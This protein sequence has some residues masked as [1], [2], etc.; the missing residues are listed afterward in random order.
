MRLATTNLQPDERPLSIPQPDPARSRKASHEIPL[1]PSSTGASESAQYL[2]LAAQATNDALR[3]WDVRTGA[4]DWPQGLESLLGYKP[5][6]ATREIGFWQKNIHP[7]DRARTAL[8]LRDALDGSA[9][10]WSGEYRFRSAHGAY[11]HL[12]ERAAI[13]RDDEGQAVRVV[14]SLM[15]ITARKQLQD[16]LVRSQKMEAFGQLAAGVAHDFNNF[17]TTILGYSDLLLEL[18][19]I[20]GAP[21]QHIGEIRQAAKRASALTGQLMAFSR[22]QP[23]ENRVVEV[24]S[25]ITNLER[26][27]LRLLG[28]HVTVECHLHRSQPAAY[29][30]VDPNQLTQV[31]LNLAVNARDAMPATAAASPSAPAPSASPVTPSPPAAPKNCRPAITPSSTLPTT[32]PA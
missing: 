25:I 22:R 29:I 16:Q 10:L 2:A 27:V 15:D 11:H 32:A 24:N 4:L 7:D 23:L 3:V 19:A 30:K 13:E 8:S 31:I 12:L 1:P 18:P 6:A 26:S 14:G 28:D 9:R 21:A 5:T 17:L 20:K